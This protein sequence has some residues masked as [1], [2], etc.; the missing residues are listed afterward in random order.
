MQT[1]TAPILTATRRAHVGKAAFTERE[2]GQENALAVNQGDEG[3][4][5]EPSH[6]HTHTHTHRPQH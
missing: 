5:Q 2:I 3:F 1:L 4:F 6:T